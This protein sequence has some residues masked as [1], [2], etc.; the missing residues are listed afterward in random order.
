VCLDVP[1]GLDGRPLVTSAAEYVESKSRNRSNPAACRVRDNAVA[2]AV[3]TLPNDSDNAVRK[4]YAISLTLAVKKGLQPGVPG[5]PV[6]ASD[7][8]IARLLRRVQKR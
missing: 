4:E 2:A 6:S 8:S 3:R 7:K 5:L 1:E